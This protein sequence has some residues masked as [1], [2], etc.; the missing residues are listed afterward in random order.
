MKF[1][2]FFVDV[3]VIDKKGDKKGTYR[4][5][6]LNVLYYRDWPLNNRD[7]EV[8][9][10]YMIGGKEVRVPLSRNE[11]D[12]LEIENGLQKQL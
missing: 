7:K 6:P 9:A 4:V 8:T 1:K 10:L 2:D 12:E 5:N 11:M 3:P